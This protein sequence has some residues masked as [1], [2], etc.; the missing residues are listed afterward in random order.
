[1]GRLWRAG[2]PG[3]TAWH[4]LTPHAQISIMLIAAGLGA[5]YAY[6]LGY[7][8]EIATFESQYFASV[9]AASSSCAATRCARR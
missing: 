5:W 7:D 8:A 3:D 2:A 6:K 4:T 1:M 9:S